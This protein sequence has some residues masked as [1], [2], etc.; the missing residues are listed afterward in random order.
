M[1]ANLC[2][3]VVHPDVYGRRTTERIVE[4]LRA[5]LPAD[6]WLQRRPAPE[7]VGGGVR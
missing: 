7:S 5:Q 3:I 1:G 6:R 2:S 4:A